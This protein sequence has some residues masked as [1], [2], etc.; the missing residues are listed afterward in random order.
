MIEEQYRFFS[1][2]GSVWPGGPSTWNILD[3]DRLRVIA[4]TMDGEQE[5]EKLAI[6]QLRKHIDDLG[7]DVYEVHIAPDGNL[8]SQSTDPNDDATACPWYPSTETVGPGM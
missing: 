3:W 4:V 2:I 1:P 6:E 5:D 8:L 7:P